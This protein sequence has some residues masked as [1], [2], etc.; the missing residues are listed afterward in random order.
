MVKL[1]IH[2]AT[3]NRAYI[4]SQAYE[5]LK[6]QTC[7]DFEW[8]ITD[9][10][11]NDGTDELVRR[12]IDNCEV[13]PIVYDQLPHVGLPRAL[14]SGVQKAR[15]EWYMRLDSDDYL[16]SEAVEKILNWISEIEKDASFVGVGF[17]RCFPDGRYMKNQTPVID[18]QVGY[19]DAT[20]IERPKYRLDMDMCEASRVDLFKQF[21]FQAWTSETFAPEQLNYNEIALA[22][23]KY[24]WR[25]EKLYVCQYLPDGQTRDDGLVK[26][27]PMG[28]A[29]MHNQNMKIRKSF[30]EK[31]KCAMQMTALCI[32]AGHV[33]YLTK[34][35]CFLATLI[36]FPLGI[37]LSFRRQRQYAKIE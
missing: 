16:K 37:A 20:N 6:A 9:D 25:A 10:G 33:R 35:N 27:N 15:S 3:Y 19:I 21:P 17:A 1:T 5:S 14:N 18:P 11:S 2:T 30:K 36:T 34:T 24:R 12:W 22:G 28:F 31:C 13:F 29:M 23:Y 8:I 7:K 4:L 32:Y 26:R